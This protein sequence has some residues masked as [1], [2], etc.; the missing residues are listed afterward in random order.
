MNLGKFILTVLCVWICVDVAFAHE[1]SDSITIFTIG[2]STMADKPTD[3]EKQERGWGQALPELL[4]G[5]VRV[6]NHAM[7]GRS[8]KS[9]I[10][11]GRWDKVMQRLKEGDYV[12]IQFGHNDEKSDIALHTIPGQSFDD[13]LRRFIS[14]TRSKGAT[15]ILL[16]SIVRRNFPPEGMKEHHYTYERE[17][18]VLVDTHGEYAER[19]KV[20]AKD[21]NVPF[22]DI[23]SLTHDYVSN[24]GPEKSKRLYMWIPAGKYEFCPKGKIDNTHLNIYGA[25]VI[26]S[27]IIREIGKV[28]PDLSP[29]IKG[30]IIHNG[31]PWFDEQGN[32]INAHGACVIEDGGRY[33][34][35]GEYKSDESNAF[36]GFGCYSSSDM[37]NWR[38]ERVVLPVQK[39]GILGPNRVGERV[40]V[41]R[42]PKTGEYIMLMHADDL[43]YK[44]PYIGI[45]VCS[46][47]NGD[48]KLLG[49]IKYNGEPIK[50][51]DMGTFQDED[52]TGYLLIHHG[53]I[54]RLSDDYRSIDA[55]VANVKGM[56][57]SP[58]MFKK[59]GTYFL[60]T[61]NLTSWERNDNYY[62][63][64]SSIEGPWERHGCFCPEGTLTH[65]S[66]T[67][68][69]F[70]LKKGNDVIPIFMGDR[71]S[72]PHQASA[73]TYVW[74][75]ITINGKEISIPEYWHSWDIESLKPA[76]LSGKE[77]KH[78]WSSNSKGD[79][80]RIPFHGRKI[81]VFGKTDNLG[82][83]ATVR[84]LDKEGHSLHS[85]YV[86]FYSKVPDESVRFVSKE[87][88]ENDYI[89]E[90]EV[91]GE[92]P[93]WYNKRGDRYGSN[94][95]Y[96][97]VSKVI[98][99]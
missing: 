58:A 26:A 25:K 60:L 55:Q 88:S 2:D 36:P 99:D 39:D 45:A 57:E 24:L 65:N 1:N 19:P 17:G 74:M 62:F 87:Y 54:Y 43:G 3:K 78:Q 22:V 75:P 30:K 50:R 82:G 46:T 35:F 28:V 23:T 52:G 38:F 89:L 81:T 18:N 49:A 15:P 20:I 53:P 95:F 9:F 40:K 94:D 97:N 27:M 63:T 72:F 32:I 8:T 7:N 42:C 6:E 56:G 67:T 31:T 37:V 10:D 13:N 70:P 61:S 69:V 76:V 41:M 29:Y 34:L 11:E 90:I 48:Y 91:A 84:V 33:W 93:V 12:I 66:Q 47:I 96:V 80:T 14:D 16:N 64:A 4:Q 68:Y 85:S 98:V 77:L 44:D 92:Q 83:Y 86:D 73:A 51:W 79:L 71:W 5:A 59:N 21:M